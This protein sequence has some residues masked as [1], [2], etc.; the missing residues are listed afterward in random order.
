MN[1]ND[2]LRELWCGQP[3]VMAANKEELVELV[4]KKTRQFDRMIFRRN[5]RECAASLVVTAMFTF[6]AAHTT[7]PL[8]RAGYIIVAA[9]GLWII[10]FLIRYGRSSAPANP[11]QAL[12]AY[13]HALVERYDRQIRL[14][15]SVKYWYLLPMWIGLLIASTGTLLNASRQRPI[16]WY[17]F[18]A[19]AIYTAVFA[20]VWWLNESYGVRRLSSERARVLALAGDDPK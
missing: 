12:D 20:F 9:S 1:P 14:L 2:E 16:G 11:D 3:I 7:D 18:F 13:R 10:F 6:I 5:L 17:D 15:G 4:Q 8:Q 19:P